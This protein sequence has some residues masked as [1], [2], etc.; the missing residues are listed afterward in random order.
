MIGRS[1]HVLGST[2]VAGDS[3]LPG[4]QGPEPTVG[5]LSA[6]QPS[7]IAVQRRVGAGVGTAVVAPVVNP[8][9]RAGSAAHRR[10]SAANNL[11]TAINAPLHLVGSVHRRP[12]AASGPGST[13]NALRLLEPFARQFHGPLASKAGSAVVTGNPLTA[14]PGSSKTSKAVKLA[15]RLLSCR[16]RE[17]LSG[18]FLSAT[19]SDAI[20]CTPCALFVLVLETLSYGSAGSPMCAMQATSSREPTVLRPYWV[21]PA[22]RSLES[23]LCCLHP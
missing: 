20:K 2:P 13:S 16:A 19:R 18:H 10:P 9:H 23:T 7:A 15:M 8:L 21:S 12:S 14:V 17:D 3:D 22:R 6:T 5:T 1:A 11:G 4:T